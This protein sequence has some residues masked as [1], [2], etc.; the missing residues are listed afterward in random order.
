M[1]HA[2]QM[3][4][5][6]AGAVHEKARCTARPATSHVDTRVRCSWQQIIDRCLNTL[7]RTRRRAACFHY[8][9]NQQTILHTTSSHSC[10]CYPST[11]QPAPLEPAQPALLQA[12]ATVSNALPLWQYHALSAAPT[13]ASV[14]RP[15]DGLEVHPL[16]HHLPQ[17]AHL[18]QLGHMGHRLLDGTLHLSI[19]GEAA[20]AIP[21]CVAGAGR[22]GVSAT[23]ARCTLESCRH[24][25]AL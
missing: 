3:L 11:P 6:H 17:R 23:S 5:V 4:M 25:H 2:S 20:Q 1:T 10:N 16:L 14:L 8:V 21:V 7:A 12:L 22:Q 24:Q 18:A 13:A 9:L 19:G 15:L